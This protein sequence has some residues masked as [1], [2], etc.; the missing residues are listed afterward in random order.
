MHEDYAQWRY[1]KKGQDFEW[2]DRRIERF[3]VMKEPN[4]EQPRLPTLPRPSGSLCVRHRIC[5]KQ[6]PAVVAA[7]TI[8]SKPAPNA[9]KG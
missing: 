9:G 8:L 6:M 1:W 4:V 7:A 3:A 5:K 2:Y